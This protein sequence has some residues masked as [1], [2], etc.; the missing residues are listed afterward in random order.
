MKPMTRAEKAFNLAGV[1]IPFA[2]TVLAVVVLWGHWVSWRDLAIM[3]GMYLATAIGITVG[4]HR[5]L[6]HR[7]FQTSKPVEYVFAGLGSL[8]LQGP[9]IAWVAD[10]RKHHA[11][12][13][14]EGDPH[15]PHVSHGDGL[16]GVLR[17]IYHAHVGWL[18]SDWGRADWKRY[19]GELTED[20]VMVAMSRHYAAFLVLTF[21]LPALLGFALTGT[22]L[23]AAT[24]FL[25]GGLVRVFFVHHVTWSINSICH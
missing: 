13:D 1:V 3:A 21:T 10:H 18:W 22:V 9:V 7:A 2:G 25:W 14:H 8:A 11:H 12:A 23:G 19:A 6:T 16:A 24:G 4:Y 20:R 15:S 5:L 17:G